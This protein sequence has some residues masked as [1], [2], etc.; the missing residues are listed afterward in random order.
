MLLRGR[1]S[2]VSHGSLQAPLGKARDSSV[3]VCVQ[4]VG[5][6]LP[7]PV[8][9]RG[10]LLQQRSLWK[11]VLKDG[12]NKEQREKRPFPYS[13]CS[14]LNC[15]K[16]C[17]TRCLPGCDPALYMRP[18]PVVKCI[19]WSCVTV[20]FCFFCNVVASILML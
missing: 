9:V 20:Y 15:Y 7:C 3:P 1:T 8:L 5:A 10:C 18:D 16:H 14:C 11:A 4:G 2:R 12:L 13:L 6:R 17:L 19:Q